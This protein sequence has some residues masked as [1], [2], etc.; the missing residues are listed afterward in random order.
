MMEVTDRRAALSTLVSTKTVVSYGEL[1]DHLKF[2]DEQ[3]FETFI[4]NAIYDGCVD[5]Q[6]DPEK[7]TF[8]VTDF[9]ECIVPDSELPAIME[10]LESWS[11]YIG[12]ILKQLDVEIK[13]SDADLSERIEAEKK[14]IAELA[15]KKE[16]QND[17]E[18][19]MVPSGILATGM[20]GIVH[21]LQAENKEVKR[22]RPNIR[23]RH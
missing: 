17:R 6:L 9:S 3:E 5:G 18:N 13:K 7:R 15:A 11:G 8:E 19:G 16:D 1:M 4:I 14:F 23:S 2:A 20:E 10:T 12:S 22:F 21:V